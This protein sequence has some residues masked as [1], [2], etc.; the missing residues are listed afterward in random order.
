MSRN[1]TRESTS[2]LVRVGFVELIDAA[3]L[4][5]AFEL[6]FFA[7]EGLSVSL[8]R[9]IGWGNVRDKLI[10]GHLDASHAVLG[11]SPLSLLG[12]DRF[13]AP[14]TT[15]MSLGTGGNAITLSRNLTDAGI[16]T[17]EDLLRRSPPIVPVAVRCWLMCLAARCTT[18]FSATGC[19][20]GESTLIAMC[21][22]VCFLRRR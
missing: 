6:G 17:A 14:L 19:Q 20:Q 10:Y 22:F 2:P 12:R 18:I 1:V 21:G 5:A 8:E 9:Q 16:A 13:P 4:I 7:E 3:P 15:I 11:L